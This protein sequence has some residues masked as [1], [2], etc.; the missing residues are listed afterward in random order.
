[1]AGALGTGRPRG[2]ATHTAHNNSAQAR[3]RINYQAPHAQC[4]S[5]NQPATNTASCP[6]NAPHP[7]GGIW[8][9][10]HTLSVA[11]RAHCYVYTAPLPCYHNQLCGGLQNCKVRRTRA[12]PQI[13]T[14]HAASHLHRPRPTDRARTSRQLPGTG[15]HTIIIIDA[16]LPS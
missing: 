15:L 3:I 16:T 13:A 7:P 14:R 11:I 10:H 5:D 12:R 8:H 4:Q 1:M 9:A 6:P 2:G